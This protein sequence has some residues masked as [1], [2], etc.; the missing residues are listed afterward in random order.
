MQVYIKKIGNI[1]FGFACE[2]QKVA[3]TNFGSDETKVIEGIETSLGFNASLTMDSKLPE[4]AEQTFTA[5][6][7]I[8]IGKGTTSS[9]HL[10]L[11]RLP[12]YTQRVLKAVARIP[13]GYVTSYGAVAEA[14]GGGAR[15]VGNAM[16]NNPLAPI[17]PCH[18]VVNAALGLGGYSGG[19][20]VKYNFLKREAKGFAEPK[21][22]PLDGGMLKVFP[23]EFML[24][25]LEKKQ[26]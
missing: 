17:V 13:V 25:K 21:N 22:V 26:L 20:N 2:N 12:A 10:D 4:F 19:L 3:A 5:L 16:A 9:I 11:H 23:V 6:N 15:A 18:R 1:W 24:S 14:V 8:Y 7:D